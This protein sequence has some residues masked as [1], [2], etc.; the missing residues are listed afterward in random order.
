[1]SLSVTIAL[2]SAIVGAVYFYIRRKYSFFQE[3]GF[4][5][6]KPEFPFGN[7]KGVGKK[8]HQ[9]YKMKE[10]YE[11]FKGKAPAFGIYFFI[12]PT[13]VITDL[14]L[15]KNVLARD[16]DNF[17]NRGLYFNEKDDPLGAQLF[18][19]ENTEWKTL[20]GKLT[21][22]FSSG[23]MKMMFETV[24]AVADLMK[25]Q[26]DKDAEAGIIE[27]KNSLANFTTD[28]IG[29]VAF[30]LEMNSISNPDAKFRQMGKKVFDLD[31][32]VQFKIIFLNSFMT[33]ARKLR[34]TLFSAE[35][36]NFFVT[37]IRETVNYRQEKK[38]QRNDVMNLLM[39][40][41][42]DGTNKEG[43]ISFNELAANCFV[44]F[45]AGKCCA[46]TLSYQKSKQ[47]CYCTYD[48]QL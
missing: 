43:T 20:R 23:K 10:L 45:F 16:F 14:E 18:T 22:T 42:D 40:L 2:L 6:E 46:I 4:L 5:H 39:N 36:A 17:H 24:I 30:G 7:L 37:T 35:V 26:F 32:N 48:L 11:R 41:L 27:V 9:V 29:N 19:L 12:T 44:F 31:G 47:I 33:L 25:K 1:M 3:N 21:P 13:V 28:V 38:I 8:F 34:M 15:V